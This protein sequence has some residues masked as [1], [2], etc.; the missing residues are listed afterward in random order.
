[1]LLVE[2]EYLFYVDCRNSYQLSPDCKSSKYLAYKPSFKKKHL[3]RWME[4]IVDSPQVMKKTLLQKIY[5]VDA[6]EYVVT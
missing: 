6:A 2:K 4:I 1:M 5:G 3:D